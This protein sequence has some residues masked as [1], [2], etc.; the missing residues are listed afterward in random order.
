MLVARASQIRIIR[1]P[2]RPGALRALMPA[3][4]APGDR[5]QASTDAILLSPPAPWHRPPGTPVF[6]PAACSSSGRYSPL[7]VDRDASAATAVGSHP[8]PLHRALEPA[9]DA[10]ADLPGIVRPREHVPRDPFGR[11][12]RA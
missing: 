2:R 1:R 9:R 10:G 11:G 5:R 3:L 12:D 7:D 4:R 6:E 8:D